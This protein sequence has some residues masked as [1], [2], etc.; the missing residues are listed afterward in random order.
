[1]LEHWVVLSCLGQRTDKFDQS[2]VNYRQWS[3]LLFEDINPDRERGEWTKLFAWVSLD[4]Q[5]SEVRCQSNGLF[6]KKHSA[7]F[8]TRYNCQLKM[9]NFTA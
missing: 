3:A 9:N 6:L 5:L 4:M 8:S 7:V 2:P 1:M